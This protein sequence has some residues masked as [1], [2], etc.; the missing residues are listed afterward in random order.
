MMALEQY[1]KEAE[2]IASAGKPP[3]KEERTLKSILA[4]KEDGVLFNKM[5]D[6]EG[7]DDLAGRLLGG[8][9]EASDLS[10][11]DDWRGK[12]LDRKEQGKEVSEGITP[13]LLADMV[14]KSLELKQLVNLTGSEG[15]QELLKKH[16]QEIALSDPTAFGDIR[17]GLTD[18]ENYREGAYKGLD[19]SISKDCKAIGMSEDAFASIMQETDDIKRATALRAAI[20]GDFLRDLRTAIKTISLGTLFGSHKSAREWAQELSG[21]KTLLDDALKTVTKHVTDLGGALS[22]LISDSDEVLAVF[23]G[24]VLGDKKKSPGE[25]SFRDM[26]DKMP[27]EA[28]MIKEW[29]RQRPRN[30]DSLTPAQQDTQKDNFLTGWGDVQEK[31][32]RSGR[33]GFWESI[34]VGFVRMLS[35]STFDKTKLA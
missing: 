9:L 16:V 4:D 23:A 30:F 5:L 25:T 11:L 10:T 8:S 28:D 14:A 33:V 21:K 3:E 15:I 19:E 17:A 6:A 12:F 27:T 29:S 22:K 1:R 34:V 24:Q 31:R 13:S 26:H 2:K 7:Q 32:M 20:P 18:L 35:G